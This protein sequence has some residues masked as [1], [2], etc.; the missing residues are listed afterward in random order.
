MHRGVRRLAWFAILVG[1]LSAC[2]AEPGAATDRSGEAAPPKAASSRPAAPSPTAL[3]TT[4]PTRTPAPTA[5]PTPAHPV[6]DGPPVSRSEVGLQV[7]LHDEDV[8]LIFDHLRALQVGWV[9]VQVSW[10]LYEPEPDHYDARRIQE[11]DDF[12]SRAAAGGIEVLLSVAKAPE[13]SRPTTDMDGPPA[14]YADYADFM[15]Y[16]ATRYRGQ[17]AAYELWNEPNLRREWNGAPLSAADFVALVRAGAQA[18]KAADPLALIVSGA[19]GPTG[20]NDC[21]DAID[22]RVYLGAMLEA[23]VADMVDA[24]GAHPYGWAN[25]PD[26]SLASPD[27]AAPSHNDHPSFFFRDTLWDYSAILDQGGRSE[28]QI[29]VT[30]FGWGSFDGMGAAPPSGAEYMAAVSEW[31]QASFTL[32]AFELA[33]GWPRVGPLFLWNLNY[34]PLLGTRFVASGFSLLR[35]DGSLRPAYL[36]MQ[37]MLD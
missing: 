2:R 6:Y 5:T 12:I 19:P 26:S 16:L 8:S 10:K 11:L 21:I 33:H 28:I 13:W 22:D 14:E 32:R 35:P 29:W 18:V 31:Q 7:H 34:A 17:V 1:A 3:S 25:P 36:A 23:G 9:K 20:I 27:P 24:I 15:H 37:T 4:A 30:E